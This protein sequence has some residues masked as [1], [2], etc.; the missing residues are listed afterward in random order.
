MPKRTVRV[1]VSVPVAELR[2]RPSHASELVT[3]AVLGETLT[4]TARAPDRK[5]LRAI[6]W[7]GY[8]GWVRSWSVTR[9]SAAVLKAWDSDLPVQVGTRSAQVLAAPHS[10]ATLV[11]E[12]ALGTRLPGLTRRGR[13]VETALPEGRTGWLTRSQ[14]VAVPTAPSSPAD[15]LKVARQFAGA[16]Y[17]WGGI[18]PWGC[19]C[20][21]F[22]QTVFRCCGV[23]L[24]RDACDQLR[25][26][27]AEVL[28]SSTGPFRPAD[29][30]FFGTS[31]KGVSHVAISTGG[32]RLLHA[33]GYVREGNLEDGRPDSVADLAGLLRVAARPLGRRKKD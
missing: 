18:T 5:W 3:Q 2:R 10:S 12:L 13:W 32:L 6:R 29:L 22:V 24:P 4:I 28:G 33:Y 25:A 21:G 9:P 23:P 11:C 8:R 7:D 27:R 31:R 19:D 20:S 15:V 16:P 1:F 14:L 30:L 26:L 17:L